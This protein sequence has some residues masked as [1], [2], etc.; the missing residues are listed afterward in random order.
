MTTMSG[1]KPL[2]GFAAAAIAAV[3]APPTAAQPAAQT[4]E[5]AL[6][7]FRFTPASIR[8]E[9]GRE[10]R[11][12]FVNRSGGGHDFSAKSFFGAA[13]VAPEDRG[14]LSDGRVALSG[15]EEATI[16][17]TAPAAGHYKVSCT[18]FMHSTFGMTGEI[19][20]D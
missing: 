10:Y 15:H 3:A 7:N 8:L 5:I 9:H 17:L 2:F 13:Q 12:H 14:K 4:V 18:H 6:S 1:I 20:V 11:L 19:V 16:R